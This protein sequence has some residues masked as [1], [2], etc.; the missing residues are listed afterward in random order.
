MFREHGADIMQKLMPSTPITSTIQYV[1]HVVK[2]RDIT[3]E[4]LGLDAKQT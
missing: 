4:P 1:S 2:N 3:M